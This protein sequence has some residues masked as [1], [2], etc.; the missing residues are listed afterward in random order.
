MN[1]VPHDPAVAVF[2]QRAQ[3]VAKRE[4]RGLN[5]CARTERLRDARGAQRAK[6]LELKDRERKSAK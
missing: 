6:L 3:A 4:M 1:H 5:E 2:E